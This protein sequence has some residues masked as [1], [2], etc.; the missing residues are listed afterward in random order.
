MLHTFIPHSHSENIKESEVFS[1]EWDRNCFLDVLGSIL[2]HNFEED[3]LEKFQVTE[4]NLTDFTFYSP[5]H[6]IDS[7]IVPVGH[8]LSNN[9]YSYADLIPSQ[10][11]ISPYWDRGPPVYL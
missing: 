10:L 5:N 6:E 1:C 8:E 2:E 3:H 11:T 4:N 7:G 9:D